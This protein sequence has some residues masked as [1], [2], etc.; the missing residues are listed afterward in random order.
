MLI[1]YV[2]QIRT[3]L[4]Y[5]ALSVSRHQHLQHL[6]IILAQ[7]INAVALSE[8]GFAVAMEEAGGSVPEEV[9]VIVVVESD[10][11]SIS[12]AIYIQR[13]RYTPR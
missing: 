6:P 12:K 5:Y 9:D 3:R 7:S 4:F 13:N 2:G 11:Y 1:Y 10:I 8:V